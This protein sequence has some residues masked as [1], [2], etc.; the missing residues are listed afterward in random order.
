MPCD[1]RVTKSGQ[2]PRLSENGQP[3]EPALMSVS[4]SIDFRDNSLSSSQSACDVNV[5]PPLAIST[6]LDY[7]GLSPWLATRADTYALPSLHRPAVA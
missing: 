3:V 1:T 6:G 7:N 4:H 5:F 2:E